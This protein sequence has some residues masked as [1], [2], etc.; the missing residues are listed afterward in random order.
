AGALLLVPEAD[1][2]LAL[3]AKS[4]SRDA[5]S[6]AMLAAAAARAF[7]S[8]APVEQDAVAAAPIRIEGHV[9]G[10]VAVSWTGPERPPA[11]AAFLQSIAERAGI[12]VTQL[13]YRTPLEQ[14]NRQKDELLSMA[15]H[16]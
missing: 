10:A 14:A 3:A 12:A 15:S 7:G 16:V 1:R 13:R 8:A 6:L 2:P 5:R 9:A 4:G 11:T